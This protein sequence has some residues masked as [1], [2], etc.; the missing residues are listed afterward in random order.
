MNGREWIGGQRTDERCDGRNGRLPQ[1]ATHQTNVEMGQ[2]APSVV[3]VGTDIALKVKASCPSGC[4]LRGR[5]VTVMGADAV[6]M[7]S[8]LATY[9]EKIN[10]TQG[11]TLKA[12]TEVGEYVWRI[13]FARHETE[14]T[15]HEESCLPI[16][17]KTR[18]H[19]TS[20]A[21]WGAPSPVVMNSPFKVKVGVKCSSLC[22]LTGRIVEIRN[23]SGTKIGEGTLSETPWPEVD[24]GIGT[25]C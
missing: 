3:E 22:Q 7:T 21:V 1:I 15:V 19:T 18:P 8:E 2:P 12:P 5:T 14:S 9:D 11:F 4:D 10:E 24:P 6:V 23:E 17:F 13:L 20:M 16:A 25:A